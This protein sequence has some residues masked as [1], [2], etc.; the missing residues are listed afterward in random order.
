MYVLY[1]SWL[2][3]VNWT[4]VSTT[5]ATLSIT[6]PHFVGFTID[7]FYCM[8][9]DPNV[10]PGTLPPDTPPRLAASTFASIRAVTKRI[11]P[12][13]MFMPTVGKAKACVRNDGVR[14]VRTGRSLSK[15]I[16]LYMRL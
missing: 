4:K 15:Y 10:P 1:Q 13:F 5:L 12:Q 14:R 2:P 16:Q 8:M 3:Q 7:D 11:A 6:F 9:E